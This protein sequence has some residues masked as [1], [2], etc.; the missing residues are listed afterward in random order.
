MEG[1]AFR[2]W[3]EYGARRQAVSSFGR[4][5]TPLALEST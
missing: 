4:F 1:P 3:D 5:P 2:R